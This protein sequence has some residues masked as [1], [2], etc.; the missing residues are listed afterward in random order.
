[1]RKALSLILALFIAL[2]GTAALA[3]TEFEYVSEGVTY[4]HYAFLVYSGEFEFG[5]NTPFWMLSGH[6]YGAE[7]AA[8]RTKNGLFD[9]VFIPDA[10]GVAIKEIQL[11]ADRDDVVTNATNQRIGYF[12]TMGMLFPYAFEMN[13][14]ETPP[15][16]A[17]QKDI[18]DV[19][20]QSSVWG[21]QTY[22][23]APIVVGDICTITPFVQGQTFGIKIVFNKPMTDQFLTERMWLTDDAFEE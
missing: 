14:L 2:S 3:E 9:A 23:K 5:D 20:V 1:M 19:C 6:G 22:S 7:N 16:D 10:T 11:L 18:I 15:N 8:F 21:T 13:A 17:L 4:Y 12:H